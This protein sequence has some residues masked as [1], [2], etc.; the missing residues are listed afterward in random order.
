M[1]GVMDELM[2]STAITT[3]K[4]FAT[5]KFRVEP[6]PSEDDRSIEW[7]DFGETDRLKKPRDL[8]KLLDR[9]GA[10]RSMFGYFLDGSRRVYKVDDVAFDK[11]IFPIMAGQVGIS[12]CRRENNLMRNEFFD[13][14]LVLV[15]PTL[16]MKYNRPY[17]RAELLERL[18]DAERLRRYGLTIDELLFYNL[19]ADLPYEAKAI[20]AVQSFMIRQEKL[21]VLRLAARNKLRQGSYL[22]KDGSLE[23]KIEADRNYNLSEERLRAA[24]DYVIGVS[25]SFNPSK[26]YVKRGGTD[27]GIVANLRPRERTPAYR[28]RANI[29]GEGIYFCVWYLRL[30]DARYTQNIFDGVVKVEKLL[31]RSEEIK[32]GVDSERLDL[33]SANILR[34]RNPVCFG[35][36][37]RWANHLYPIYA[38]EAFA[39]SRY[40]SEEFFLSLF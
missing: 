13:R 23:Y 1:I 40:L 6:Q 34:E 39:K 10:A 3:G 8:S 22:M 15:L 32:N 14:K 30:R 20:I 33:I 29:S 24:Y 5:K 2:G 11:N 38:T 27:S 21:S 17:L 9:I 35:A 26:C 37:E 19:D 25:K 18:N 31:V 7:L 36:D 16:A 4:R 12:C 28:Y